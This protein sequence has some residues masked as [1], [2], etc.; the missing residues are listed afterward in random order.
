MVHH[1]V[2]FWLKPGLPESE[3]HAFLEALRMLVLSPNAYSCRVGTPLKPGREDADA[4]FDFQLVIEFPTAEDYA[5]YRS[6]EDRV[7]TMFQLE[8]KDRWARIRVCDAVSAQG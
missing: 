5:A 1:T 7:H 4:T 2:Y 6:P 8:N 3:R